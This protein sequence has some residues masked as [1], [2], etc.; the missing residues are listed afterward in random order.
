[1]RNNE[2]VLFAFSSPYTFEKNDDMHKHQAR[3]GD[4][5][6]D[7]AFSVEDAKA[8]Y[9]VTLYSN[10]HNKILLPSESC[11]KRSI[12][13]SCPTRIKRWARSGHSC[14]SINLWRCHPYFCITW[15]LQRVFKLFF[16][17]LPI[18]KLDFSY[19]DSNPTP[20]ANH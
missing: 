15:W 5:V 9:N 14:F 20:K 2:G 12:I 3:H 19:Q 6:K 16:Y 11:I 18:F 7:V 13:S 17:F 8:L 4:A 1:M 10:I